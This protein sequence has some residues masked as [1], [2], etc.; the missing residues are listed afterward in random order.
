MHCQLVK[1]EGDP[2]TQAPTRAEILERIRSCKWRN[3]IRWPANLKRAF[4]HE[5]PNPVGHPQCTEIVEWTD[6][7]PPVVTYRRD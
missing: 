7:T 5:T 1:W 6:K 3:P 4:A 2:P